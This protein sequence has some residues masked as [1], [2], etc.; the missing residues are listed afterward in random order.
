MSLREAVYEIL[1]RLLRNSTNNRTRCDAMAALGC[2]AA[3]TGEKGR[4]GRGCSLHLSGLAV[5]GKCWRQD[6]CLNCLLIFTGR[7]GVSF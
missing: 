2:E 5:E 6:I 7:N 3:S 1:S 4:L